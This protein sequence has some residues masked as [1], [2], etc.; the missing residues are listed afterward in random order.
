M[1]NIIDDAV[2]IAGLLQIPL[3]EAFELQCNVRLYNHR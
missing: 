1:Y 2:T 3:A